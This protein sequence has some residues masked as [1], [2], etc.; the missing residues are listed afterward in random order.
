MADAISSL[1]GGVAGD[2]LGDAGG[3]LLGGALGGALGSGG[4]PEAMVVDLVGKLL[5]L[6]DT[7]L[8]IAKAA[9]GAFT[10]DPMA[11]AAGVEETISGLAS[12]QSPFAPLESKSDD[13]KSDAA[14]DAAKADDAA[15]AVQAGPD[16]PT[17]DS[18][19]VA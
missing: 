4:D 11:I 2:A 9:L 6:N 17:D 18:T 1:V 5:G 12:G 10:G 14:K 15:H 8:G 3:D 16:A 13:Q 19:R 7:D